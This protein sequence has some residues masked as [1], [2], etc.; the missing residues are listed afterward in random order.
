MN[1]FHLD[2]YRGQL[3]Q[4]SKKGEVLWMRNQTK[5][6]KLTEI[7]NSDILANFKFEILAVC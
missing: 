4:G 2:S 5:V 3:R 7:R 6:D 1:T